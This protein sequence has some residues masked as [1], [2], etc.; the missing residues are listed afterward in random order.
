MFCYLDMSQQQP[1]LYATLTAVLSPEEQQVI[2]VA[3]E[4][5]DKILAEQMHQQIQQ[6]QQ[7]QSTDGTAP[8]D[9]STVHTNGTS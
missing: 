7:S 3:L 9:A 8:T 4:H 5:A 6:S 2:K 1:E